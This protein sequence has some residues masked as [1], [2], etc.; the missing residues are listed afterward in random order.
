LVPWIRASD[1][2]PELEGVEL[3]EL[4]LAA[5]LVEPDPELEPVV[6]AELEPELPQP[7]SASAAVA[8]TG[9]TAAIRRCMHSSLC[10]A[11]AGGRL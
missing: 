2:L 6:E 3:L 7:A 10:G 11:A 9:T 1:L 8:T 4:V 5:V